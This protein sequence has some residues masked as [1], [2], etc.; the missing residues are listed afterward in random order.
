VSQE[1]ISFLFNSY[2]INTHKKDESVLLLLLFVFV[3]SFSF[4]A[5]FFPI[6]LPSLTR[7]S[8]REKTTT[9][10]KER[11]R[12]NKQTT[13]KKTPCLVVCANDPGNSLPGGRVVNGW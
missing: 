10:K 9:T 13:N 4:F 1:E 11:E 8:E 7:G 3:L 5:L 12:A 6:P 2:E